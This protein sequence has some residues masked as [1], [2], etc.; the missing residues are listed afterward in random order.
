MTTLETSDGAPAAVALLGAAGAV[1]R[2][3]T[4]FLDRYGGGDEHLAAHQAEVD[5]VLA[6]RLDRAKVT[7]DDV[8]GELVAVLGPDGRR[9]A[10]LMVSSSRE[11][12]ED[13]TNP[14]LGEPIEESPAIVWVK[15]LDGRYLRVNRSYTE[16][17]GVEPE[18]VSGKTDAELSP[19]ESIE[20]LRLRANDPVPM[21]PLELEYTVAAY[22]GLPA[23][24]VLRFALR[25]DDGQPTAVC[26]VAAPLSQARIARSECERLMRIERWSRLDESAIR[27]ELLD[28]WELTP[29]TRVPDPSAVGPTA[30][31]LSGDGSA[32]LAALAVERDA[33]V[34][35]AARLD[36]QLAEERQEIASLREIS[37][38]ATKRADELRGAIA[39]EQTRSSEL[40]Q[41]L[42]RAEARLEELS[43]ALETERS[44]AQRSGADA[45]EARGAAEKALGQER[46]TIEALRAELRAA[47]LEL[48][49]VRGQELDQERRTAEAL[50]AELRAAHEETERA[51]LA[52]AHV[53]DKAPKQEELTE[54]KV[55]LTQ[56]LD[57]LASARD[58]LDGAKEE[59]ERARAD[60]A[61]SAGTLEAEWE[62]KE[63]LQAELIAARKDLEQL[64]ARAEEADGRSADAEGRAAEAEARA[65]E[66]VRRAGQAAAAAEEEGAQAAAAASALEEERRILDALRH[67]L[68]QANSDA[69]TASAALTVERQ[70]LEALHAEATAAR[71]ELDAQR[72]RV[73]QAEG[74][75]REERARAED[76][77]A[78]VS[79][80]Q[81]RAEEALAASER[82]QR[83]S[84]E[85]AGELEVMR[86]TVAELSNELSAAREELDELRGQAPPA[87]PN[88]EADDAEP[89][90][91][92][93]TWTTASQ[94]TLSAALAGVS[95]WRLA[96]KQA[97]KVI[98]TEGGWE[99]VVAWAPDDGRGPMTCSAMWTADP[100]RLGG[101]ENLTWQHRL[102]V[103]GTEFGRARNRPGPT[104]LLE[105]ETAED[106]MLR[107]AAELGMGSALLL[108]IR[109]GEKAIAILEL[110]SSAETPPDSELMVALEAVALQLS[111][112][113]QALRTTHWNLGSRL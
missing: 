57:Q 24:A 83:E 66:A 46:Q 37:A 56:V 52:A 51:R 68:K 35:T 44:T 47:Q 45:E 8:G 84:A 102:D 85:A 88:P 31:A 43:S 99:A 55:Q 54:A 93:H 62:T 111:A 19:K 29:A 49:R 113:G 69:A 103:S 30:E 77:L 53:A 7:L 28:E 92:R 17:L 110:L 78:E 42:A 26:S 18:H 10:L 96:L 20:G 6:G 11:A 95:E 60:A 101:F 12:R 76:A 70:T 16:Q 1:E 5:Q 33:A 4:L 89:I 36:Q 41:A 14:L 86:Q 106:R 58:E 59:L 38:V 112:V 65:D 25:S 27:E 71:A 109:D 100:A 9:Y 3:T 61:A 80:A 73:E 48:E 87:A 75:A 90:G 32:A 21:E 63:A 74:E 105:L 79:R 81:E 104:L 91:S 107:M 2:A 15:D 72:G 82:L 22:D 34:A 67:E 94:R 23:F 108:P 40:E 64:L 50:R 39:T 97:A 13:R 98:G